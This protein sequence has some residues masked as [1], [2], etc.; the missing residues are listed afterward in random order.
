M[1]FEIC[2]FNCDRSIIKATL[3]ADQSTFPAVSPLALEDFLW[4]NNLHFPRVRY[5]IC[6]FGYDWKKIKGTLVEE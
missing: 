3:H 2:K 5:K 6:K 4:H 1:R